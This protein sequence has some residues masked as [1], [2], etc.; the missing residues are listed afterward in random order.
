ME[1][2]ASLVIITPAVDQDW[3]VALMPLLERG[4]A[5]TVLLLDPV[6]F[7]GSGDVEGVVTLLSSLEVAHYI[8]T[9]D[10]LDGAQPR[11]GRDHDEGRVLGIG[12]VLPNHTLPDVAWRELS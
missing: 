1:Q 5:P 10:V 8:V 6:S 2:Y 12:H 3:I 9:R 11:L 7:G 4:I